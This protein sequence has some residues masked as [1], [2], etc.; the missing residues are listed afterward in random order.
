MLI[1]EFQHNIDAK[2][3]VFIPVRFRDDLGMHFIVTKGLDGCLYAYSMPEW[4]A[5]EQKIRSLPMSRARDLQRFFF[6]GAADVEVDK[7]GRILLSAGLRGYAGLT[8]DVVITG[9]SNHAEIWDAERWEQVCS[10]ITPE[11]VAQ[12][13]DELGF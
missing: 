11:K 2:G 8:R 10:A 3:R 9:A 12:A 13:M 5:L 4:Q 7:Q 6:A 1:G